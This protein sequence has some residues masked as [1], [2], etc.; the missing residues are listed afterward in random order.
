MHAFQKGAGFAQ[1]SYVN[2]N[3]WVA[4]LSKGNGRSTLRSGSRGQT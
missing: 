4:M 2:Q 3:H 1:K